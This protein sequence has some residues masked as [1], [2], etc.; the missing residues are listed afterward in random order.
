M[1]VSKNDLVSITR[2]TPEKSE[3]TVTFTEEGKRA[4]WLTGNTL[5]LWLYDIGILFTLRGVTPAMTIV[6]GLNAVLPDQGQ[7]APAEVAPL[8][9]ALGPTPGSKNPSATP[10]SLLASSNTGQQLF[11]LIMG[12]FSLLSSTD[13]SL[14]QSCWLCLSTGPPYYEKN[15]L[16]RQLQ[17]YQLLYVL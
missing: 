15:N 1:R 7:L 11:N 6:L 5:G 16:I 3:I 13:H 17:P 9:R 8:A 14:K 2:T 4:N 10:A 12:A